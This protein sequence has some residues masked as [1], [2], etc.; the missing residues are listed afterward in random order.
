LPDINEGLVA[1]EKYTGISGIELSYE[2]DGVYLS[3]G[4]SGGPLNVMDIISYIKRKEIEG[5]NLG[6]ISSLIS[7]G[8]VD[9]QKVAEPQREIILDEE[10]LVETDARHMNLF[11]TLPRPMLGK[12]VHGRIR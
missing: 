3:I 11:V 12:D 4:N 8:T 5:A 9:K 2:E 7:S 6:I 10:P 1:K